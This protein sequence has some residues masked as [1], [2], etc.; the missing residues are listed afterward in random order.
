MR[1][2]GAGYHRC[3]PFLFRAPVCFL[4][5]EDT[6][7]IAHLSEVYRLRRAFCMSECTT[8]YPLPL[9]CHSEPHRPST[10]TLHPTPP[11]DCLCFFCFPPPTRNREPARRVTSGR[12]GAAPA[13]RLVAQGASLTLGIAEGVRT[14]PRG[15]GGDRSRNVLR[16]S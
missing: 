13:Y 6:K 3:F 5:A 15:V 11:P 9:F 12:G 14:D 7:S 8:P 10:L 16:R 2:C 1:N 4:I